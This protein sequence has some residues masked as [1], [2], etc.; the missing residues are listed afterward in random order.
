[1]RKLG[2]VVATWL[3]GISA[4]AMFIALAIGIHVLMFRA[5]TNF[6]EKV[7]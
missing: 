6:L 1:M 7:L 4:S 2:L 3:I 5:L